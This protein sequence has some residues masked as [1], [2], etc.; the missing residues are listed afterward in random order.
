MAGRTTFRGKEG[1]EIMASMRRTLSGFVVAAAVAVLLVVSAAPVHAK[2]KTG[3]GASVCD[4][5]NS[6]IAFISSTYS[7]PLESLL[8]APWLLAADIYNC[9]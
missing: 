8:L 4:T 9:D 7:E 3:S 6:T 2:A 5:I 1:E